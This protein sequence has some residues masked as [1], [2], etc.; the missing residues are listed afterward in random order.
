MTRKDKLKQ[1]DEQI[2]S[3]EEELRYFQQKEKIAKSEIRRL[4]RKDRTHRLCVRGGMLEHFLQE[5]EL[6]SDDQ[7]QELLTVAF[8]QD[9]VVLRLRRMITVAK[10]RDG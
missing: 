4:T 2:I 7:V 5:P 10:S 8:R 3:M 6:L 9:A 1:L